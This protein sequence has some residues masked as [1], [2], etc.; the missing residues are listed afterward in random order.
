M[1][2]FTPV[3]G[4]TYAIAVDGYGGSQGT[5]TLNW[6]LAVPPANDN[7]AGAT[8]ISG[9]YGSATGNSTLA[10]AQNGEPQHAGEAPNH[11]LWYRWVAPSNG[12]FIFTT[13]GSA[14]DTV[15]G[16]Y[17]GASLS[18][19][20][21]VASDND[22]ADGYG[23]AAGFTATAGTT[24]HIAVDGSGSQGGQVQLTWYANDHFA[25]AR[26]LDGPGGSYSG[27][28]FAATAQTGE[29][30]HAGHSEASLWFRWRAP[31][32]GTVSF[33]TSGSY[34]DTVLAAYAGSS[35]STLTQ[36]AQN[37]DSGDLSSYIEF[38]VVSGRYYYIALDGYNGAQGVFDLIWSMGAGELPA[39]SV[40]NQRALAEGNATAPGSTVFPITLSAPSAE[41]VMVRYATANG[42]ATAGEDYVASTGTLAFAP[43]EVTKRVR[44]TFTGD[45]VA[46]SNETFFLTLNSPL[47]ATIADSRGSAYI[48]N[49]DGP[50]VFVD[51]ATPLR[52][53]NSGTTPQQF[54][55]RLSAASTNTI[56]VEWTTGNGTA[57]PADFTAANGILTFAPGETQKRI[58]VLVKGDTTVEP[59]ETYRVKLTRSTM[60]LIA[61]SQGIG[62]IVNDDAAPATATDESPSQ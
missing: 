23:S 31:V 48:R 39:L 18:G 8:L 50:Q 55:V 37:D 56:T 24:Y 16:I 20:T 57:G 41:T 5:I 30:L 44:I 52:E 14:F 35:L 17:R 43:G 61:D 25:A 58:T 54:E 29:P 33:A 21:E 1:V 12:R 27:Y 42:T 15:L 47:G 38:P 22:S 19:L 9:G 3:A 11:S 2:A 10:S 62:Y 51:N 34:F 46:E 26:G 7:F 13:A 40:G 49:D 36:L 53:G 4:N 28:N 32:T 60:S 6:E 59:T 45:A